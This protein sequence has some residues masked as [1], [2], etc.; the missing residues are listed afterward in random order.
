MNNGDQWVFYLKL[1]RELPRE[2]ILMDQQFKK[3][4]K[5]LIPIGIKVLLEHVR[6][7]SST[8]VLIL[9]RSIGEYTYFKQKVGKAMKFLMMGRRVH[10][11]IASS[12]SSVNDPSV[13]KRDYYYFAKLP[14]GITSFCNAVSHEV[15]RKET[16]MLK[17]PGGI[18]PR[19]SIA[20]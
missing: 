6:K 5:T 1:T 3:S 12:F 17:W 13:M 15:D 8:H 11:Y 2:F 9:I 19:V 10:L 4:G 14:I 20:S 7:N 16:S 18:R